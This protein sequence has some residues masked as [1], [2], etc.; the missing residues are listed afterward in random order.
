MPISAVTLTHVDLGYV[1][2]PI[3]QLDAANSFSTIVFRIEHLPPTDVFETPNFCTETL[4]Q[5]YGF[6]DEASSLSESDRSKLDWAQT[7]Y[8]KLC[9][10]YDAIRLAFN[11]LVAVIT[12]ETTDLRWD[13]DDISPETLDTS[14]RRDTRSVGDSIRT[15]FGIASHSKQRRLIDKVIR[16]QQHSGFVTNKLHNLTL[17][18]DIQTDLIENLV[19]ASRHYT[20]VLNRQSERLTQ[21]FDSYRGAAMQQ[22]IDHVLTM[23][24]HVMNRQLMVA[25]VLQLQTLQ[26]VLTLSTNRL[27]SVSQLINNKMSPL[28][29][30]PTELTRALKKV[31]RDLYEAHP[32]FKVVHTN[33]AYYYSIA[34]VI[35]WTTES[36]I[37]VSVN[38][39]LTCT[40]EV[41]QLYELI[42]FPLTSADNQIY[43]QLTNVAP[44]IGYNSNERRIIKLSWE[45]LNNHCIKGKTYQCTDVLTQ[46]VHDKQSL[47]ESALID[48]DIRAISEICDFKVIKSDPK[49]NEVVIIPLKAR[50][51]LIITAA[52]VIAHLQCR[53]SVKQISLG[54]ISEIKLDCECSLQTAMFRVPS[55]LTNNC[56]NLKSQF[57]ITNRENSNILLKTL[58]YN[59]SDEVQLRTLPVPD[60]TTTVNNVLQ[61]PFRNPEKLLDLKALIKHTKENGIIA[62]S[63]SLEAHD[64]ITGTIGSMWKYIIPI[65]VILPV[66]VIGIILIACKTKWLSSTLAVM[67]NLPT[68]KALTTEPEAI[69]WVLI[70]QIILAIAC[71]LVI[72]YGLYKLIRYIKQSHGSSIITLMNGKLAPR[73]TKFY[74]VLF[75]AQCTEYIPLQAICQTV[76]NLTVQPR[77]ADF[78]LNL[79]KHCYNATLTIDW[80]DL[81]IFCLAKDMAYTLPTAV[82]VSWFQYRRLVPILKSPFNARLLAGTDNIYQSYQIMETELNL[83]NMRSSHMQTKIRKSSV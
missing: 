31:Q 15:F 59:V 8:N 45:I 29:V 24:A 63:W 2:K 53:G 20:H 18:A 74:L 69:V 34:N 51:L 60:I 67:T 55:L 70:P 32:S 33:A 43:T 40:N 25:G 35:A 37:Y 11:Q 47:C 54:P 19:N 3:H 61:D 49:N 10:T 48:N 77:V 46:Y 27:L 83:I 30:P 6:P 17:I 73:Y 39:P 42:T 72:T 5:T 16:L 81:K 38:V 28:L 7:R 26:H 79:V 21:L 65:M 50:H 36:D 80:K 23:K 14:P 56:E 22:T 66:I 68:S 57:N 76:E 52:P 71:V 9:S 4:G 44:I 82:K 64:V 12:N 75:T 1:L 62:P 41:Y 58:Y 13:T 78:K